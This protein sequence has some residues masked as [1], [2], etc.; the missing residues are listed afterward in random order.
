MARLR[1]AAARGHIRNSSSAAKACL[2]TTKPRLVIVCLINRRDSV[3][4]PFPMFSVVWPLSPDRS[5]VYARFSR[6]RTVVPIR[7]SGP[8]WYSRR[9]SLAGGPS[10]VYHECHAIA[11][12]TALGP[13]V[14]LIPSSE[15]RSSV[16]VASIEVPALRNRRTNVLVR[17][18][19][20]SRIM[21]ALIPDIRMM[22]SEIDSPPLSVVHHL[23]VPARRRLE[24][25]P[26]LGTSHIVYGYGMVGNDDDLLH[27]LSAL[28]D[29]VR[30]PRLDLSQPDSSRR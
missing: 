30:Q 18:S 28:F 6:C 5:F 21:L 4:E 11:S 29:R 1:V 25:P 26:S 12:D 15:A 10:V 22:V 14:L 27:R 19:S 17:E 20:Q 16:D 24:E 7:I 2:Q 3:P 13:T 9:R 8:P 23:P